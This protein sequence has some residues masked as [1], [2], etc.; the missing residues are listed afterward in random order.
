MKAREIPTQV[1]KKDAKPEVKTK[2]I[3]RQMQKEAKQRPRQ[4]QNEAEPRN[5]AKRE[6]KTNAEGGNFHGT[7]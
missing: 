4:T 6:T 5:E 2:E 3:P 1:P 7:A